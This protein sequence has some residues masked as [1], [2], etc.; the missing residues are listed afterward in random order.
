MINEN[1]LKRMEEVFGDNV[2]DLGAKAGDTVLCDFCNKDWTGDDTSGGLLFCSNAIC[3]DCEPKQRESIKGYN[4]E[5][6]IRAECPSD[7]SFWEWV[8]TLR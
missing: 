5:K 4:E 8:L 1:Y 3:P 7:M 6:Y 2:I